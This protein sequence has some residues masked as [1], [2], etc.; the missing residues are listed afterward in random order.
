MA[1]PSQ[2]TRRYAAYLQRIIELGDQ[3]ETFNHKVKI[4]HK[5]LLSWVVPAV[6]IK[7]KGEDF[8]LIV[9]KKYTFSLYDSANLY[10]DIEAMR[11]RKFEDYEVGTQFNLLSLL[12]QNCI[13]ILEKVQR[14][15]KIGFVEQITGFEPLPE[16]DLE[17]EKLIPKQ[18]LTFADF[19]WNIYRG[20]SLKLQ[21]SISRSP[22]FKGLQTQINGLDP[23]EDLPL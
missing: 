20:L 5:L 17:P 23:A 8:P 11:G 16:D 6:L 19:D 2:G 15:D 3:Q 4:V 12:G 14:K 21:E 1:A 7:I 18:S 13:V 22:Q 9:H 10:R